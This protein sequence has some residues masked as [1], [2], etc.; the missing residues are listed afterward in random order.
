MTKWIVRGITIDISIDTIAEDE[1]GEEYIGGLLY[2]V[3]THYYKV[4]SAR[5]AVKRLKKCLAD[6]KMFKERSLSAPLRM[7][8]FYRWDNKYVERYADK[9]EEVS[10][11]NSSM[12]PVVAWCCTDQYYIDI[13]TSWRKI[14]C[15]NDCSKCSCGVKIDYRVPA[16][17]DDDGIEEDAE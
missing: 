7:S 16:D 6:F 5:A 15:R 14:P 4:H 12:M 8:G 3:Q 11:S 17:V 13:A 9:P 1:E 2:G 10:T